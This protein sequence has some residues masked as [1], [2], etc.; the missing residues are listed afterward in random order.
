MFAVT[1]SEGRCSL[2]GVGQALEPYSEARTWMNTGQQFWTDYLPV[3]Y[4]EN[5]NFVDEQLQVG[6]VV[7]L[8]FLRFP[9]MVS[10]FL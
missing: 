3:R 1:D 10:E 5:W 4:D 7:L 6:L 2:F 9:T 8:S